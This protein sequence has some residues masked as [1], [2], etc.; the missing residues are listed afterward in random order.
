MSS[1]QDKNP[2]QRTLGP[3]PDLERHLPVDWWRTLFNA[4]YLDTDGDVVEN[5]DITKHEVD[6]I[7]SALDLKKNDHILDLCCGQGRHTIE[8]ANRGYNFLTGIDR[9]GY[10]IRLARRRAKAAF[11]KIQFKEGDARHFSLSSNSQDC[12]IMMGNSF[13]YFDNEED[14]VAV[15]NAVKKV[16]KSEGKLALDLTDGDWM[17]KHFEPRS[18][19]WI[20]KNQFVCRERSLSQDGDRL[21]SREVI[22]HAE[23]GVIADQFYAERLYSKVRI[24]Q[25]L[26][27]VGFK[28][29]QHH[30]EIEPDSTR[31]EDLG[32]MARRNL[33]TALGPVKSQQVA[34]K[35]RPLRNISVLMGDP[36]LPDTVKLGGKFN[37]EDIATINKLKSALA[38]L[39]GYKFH[40]ID[41]HATLVQSLNKIKSDFVLNLCDEGFM[42]NATMEMHVPAFLEMQG[43]SYTGANPQSLVICYNK[44]IVR[45]IAMSC[46][47]PVP[48]ETYFGP[49]DQMVTIPS[50]LPA[51]IKPC[52]GDSSIGITSKAVVHSAEE[53]IEYI[54]GLREQLPR[55]SILVQEFLTGR[56]FSVGLVGNPSLG[57]NPLPVLEVDYSKLDE[58]LPKILGYESKWDPNS[59]YW[60]EISYK[61]AELDE[62]SQRNLINWS[63][64]LFE[65]LGCRDYARFDFRADADGTLKLLEANPNPGWCW[66][67]KLNL[68]A[69]F[70]GLSYSDLLAKIIEAAERRLRL[71]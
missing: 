12:V 28:D 56:E 59:P 64:I 44:A 65:R 17:R 32:M 58:G 70:A 18:W 63:S 61:K 36:S 20:D 16:L 46:D 4:V 11:L 19:E 8:L 41:S 13:G 21:I 14:D 55:T 34:D 5:S 27:K 7:I 10:L 49:D 47:I 1:S 29:I 3:L 25:L 40:Y 33:I 38:E 6:R 54:A 60:S 30:A 71:R 52:E 22:V 23:H 9:S 45:S 67:G 62:E 15:L 68:M 24:T 43:I 42:N 37:E 48:L 69:S 51:L 66:D 50:I 35:S 2:T 31:H 53:A 26:E 39:D 57:L